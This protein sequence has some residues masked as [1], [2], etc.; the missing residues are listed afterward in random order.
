MEN[1]LQILYKRYNQFEDNYDSLPVPNLFWMIKIYKES[2]K[3]SV[4]V[5][6][7]I[8]D[9]MTEDMQEKKSIVK[10]YQM[11]VDMFNPNLSS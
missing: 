9:Y 10:N 6:Q 11:K 4:N 2:L 8:M 3:Y 7:K 5:E 1:I